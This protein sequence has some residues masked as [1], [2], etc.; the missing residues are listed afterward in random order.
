M[1]NGVSRAAKM[2]MIPRWRGFTLI[3][4]LVV[5]AILAILAAIAV[6]NLLEA[7]VRSKVSRTRSDLRTAAL[8][9]EAYYVD[10]NAYPPNLNLRPIS[11]PVAYVT[12]SDI[13]DLFAAA[14]GWPT[15]GYLEAVATSDPSFL[16]AFQV[17]NH[18]PAE[19][20][21]LAAHRY[22]VFSNGP[23]RIDEAL[24][25]SQRSFDDMVRKPGADLGYFYDPTN[26][27]VSRGDI[28]RSAR[29]M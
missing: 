13:P 16:E 8:A 24:A 21:D 12:L 4:L 22:F 14:T 2:R 23:D 5:V 17:T 19:R 3:E 6:P 10:N 11:T 29:L 26:G 18:T 15:I 9:L 27:T 28:V 1:S 7:Q 25:N 20:A